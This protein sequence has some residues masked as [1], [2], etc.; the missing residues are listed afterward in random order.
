[1]NQIK[2]FSDLDTVSECQ[3]INLAATPTKADYLGQAPQMYA[4]YRGI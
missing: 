3:S 4:M 1:M 2:P